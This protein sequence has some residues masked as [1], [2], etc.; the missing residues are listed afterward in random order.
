VYL[1]AWQVSENQIFHRFDERAK[2]SDAD[3]VYEKHSDRLHEVYSKAL[4]SR[5]E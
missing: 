1:P 4:L 5:H 3:R 2:Q